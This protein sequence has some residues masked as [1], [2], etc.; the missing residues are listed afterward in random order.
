MYNTLHVR[1]N[2]SI[3]SFLC[4]QIWF[5]TMLSQI[6]VVANGTVSKKKAEEAS[7]IKLGRRLYLFQLSYSLWECIPQTSNLIHLDGPRSFLK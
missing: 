1:S 3:Y 6:I 5:E 7:T 2:K 4:P